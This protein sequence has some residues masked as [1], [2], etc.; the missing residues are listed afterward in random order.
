MNLTLPSGET[1]YPVSAHARVD[2]ALRL[3][4]TLPLREHGAALWPSALIL[5]LTVSMYFVER[6]EGVRSLRALF[7]VLFAAAFIL[8]TVVLARWSG[9][10]AQ[11]LLE[12]QGV[13]AL[14]AAT[15]TIVRAAFWVGFDLWVWLWLLVLA[16]RLEPWL[17][18]LVL[19]TFCLRA[20]L[21]PSFLASADGGQQ[22]TGLSLLRAAIQESDGQ[23]RAGVTA[24]LYL[25]LGALGL[26]FNF[27]ALLVAVVGL[28]QDMLGLDLSYVRAF[29]SPRNYFALLVIG[30][31]ALVCMEPVRAALSALLYVEA[32]LARD[33]LALRVLVERC[34]NDTGRARGSAVALLLCLLSAGSAHAQEQA[35]QQPPPAATS[36]TEQAEDEEEAAESSSDWTVQP[37]DDVCERAQHADLEVNVRIDRILKDPVF[38]EFPDQRWDSKNRGLASLFERFAKWLA[39]L[40]RDEQAHSEHPSSLKLPGAIFFVVLAVLAL[41]VA[42][43]M[44]ARRTPQAPPP[45]EDQSHQEDPWARSADEHLQDARR[46]RDADLT[47]ALRS[48]YLATLIGLARRG[49]LTLSAERTNGQYLRDLRDR[50]ERTLFSSL[51]RV[52]DLVQYG[53]H[54]PSQHDFDH[55]LALA[56]QLVGDRRP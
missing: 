4:R 29:L 28:G 11:G 13:P 31:L 17:S 16:V 24:E 53:R 21:L 1:L 9:R 51:T 20:A 32:R 48:L 42:W 2:R 7:A 49:H 36:A 19:P 43:F 45:A 6:V 52:F 40:S 46:M 8:R 27:G 33:G 34:V 25:L 15:Q 35:E 37:C 44:F 22:D 54:T 56:E 12:A 47:A 14:H 39:E 5:T 18:V 30:G 10:R 26:A 55:C 38:R 3:L 23:R 50:Q 41:G